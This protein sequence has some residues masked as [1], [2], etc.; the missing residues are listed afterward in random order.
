MMDLPPVNV[1]MVIIA[2]CPLSVPAQEQQPATP[3]R[4]LYKEW[5]AEVKSLDL[6]EPELSRSENRIKKQMINT[7]YTSRFTEL[8]R[9]H[10]NDD[11]WLQCLVWISAEGV[12]GEALDEMF[13][14]L[15]AHA[16]GVGNTVQL[17]L[18]MSEF[19]TLSSDRIDPA[20]AAIVE[21]HDEPGVRGAALF[22]LAARKKRVAEEDGDV[23]ALATA[24]QLLDR[25]LQEYPSV[26]TYRGENR[27]TAM[28]LLQELRSPVAITKMAPIT[29][30][31]TIAG[32]EFELNESIQGRVAVLAF[33]GHWCAPCVA[34]HVIQKEILSMFSE[35]NGDQSIVI[36]EINSDG[37]DSLEDV[38]AKIARDSLDWIVV[39]DGRNGAIANQWMVKTWPTYFIIDANGRIRCMMRGN[40]GRH[41][42]E[43]VERV[44]LEGNP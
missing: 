31:K 35:D 38:H 7:K 36:V 11:V 42:L 5:S 25:V 15:P 24:E 10:P 12:P 14:M 1:L 27:R 37:L 22:A 17:Q 29:K 3:Y 41:L 16:L 18:L 40:V 44:V 4:A 19:I 39:A 30:G 33:S 9:T 20:L 8:A 34:M 32:A 23:E 43:K 2:T 28:K 6:V 13:D 26:R 21:D